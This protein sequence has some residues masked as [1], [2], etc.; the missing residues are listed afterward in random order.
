MKAW[1]DRSHPLIGES[2][3]GAAACAVLVHAA[4]QPHRFFEPAGFLSPRATF[5]AVTSGLILVGIGVHALL[6]LKDRQRRARFAS[7]RRSTFRRTT[8]TSRCCPARRRR[9]GRA[10]HGF[11]ALKYSRSSITSR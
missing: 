9:S 6:R 8:R 7:R 10:R 11:V 2:L 1:W 5:A 4:V 3:L